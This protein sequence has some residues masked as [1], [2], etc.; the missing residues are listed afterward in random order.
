MRDLEAF[1]DRK[2]IVIVSINSLNTLQL[3]ILVLSLFPAAPFAVAG[4]LMTEILE[5]PQKGPNK[6]A[7]QIQGPSLAEPQNGPADALCLNRLCS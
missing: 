2:T 5:S 1:A 4:C 6:C 7:E 3:G